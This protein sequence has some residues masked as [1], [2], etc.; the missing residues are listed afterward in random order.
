MNAEKAMAFVRSHGIVLVSAKGPVPRLTDVIAAEPVKGSWLAHPK[1]HEIFSILQKLT[2][3][4]D[5][6]VCRLV[7]GHVTL[8][9]RRLWPAL[10]KM[11]SRFSSDQLAQVSDE[12]TPSG[13]HVSHAVAY[14]QW[15]PREVLE[16]AQRLTER[17]AT[18]L[19]GLVIDLPRA[20]RKRPRR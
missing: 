16:E 18:E 7:E 1:S 4:P 3:S 13:K 12:H 8:V 20:P 9:H 11:A 2:D 5:I 19:L 15:V 6:L 17:Q 14:P 10:V